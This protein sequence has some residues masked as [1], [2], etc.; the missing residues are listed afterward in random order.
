MIEQKQ[1]F[2]AIDWLRFPLAVMVVFIH[3]LPRTEMISA[4]GFPLTSSYGI[5][6]LVLITCSHVLPRLAVPTFFVI[7]SYLFYRGMSQWEWPRYVEKLKRRCWTLLIPYLIWN[8]VALLMRRE[9]FASV[10]INTF[11]VCENWQIVEN[12]LGWQ[13]PA[14][15]PVNGPLWFVRDLMVLV[16]LSPLLYA[17][18]RYGSHLFMAVMAVLFV[19]QTF[20]YIP[21]LCIDGLFFWTLGCYFALHQ[22]K[23]IKVISS[24][25]FLWLIATILMLC[26]CVYQDSHTTL[27][28]QMMFQLFLLVGVPT[29]LMGGF[30]CTQRLHLKSSKPLLQSCFLLYALHCFLLAPLYLWM[31]QHALAPGLIG[32]ILAY[33][34]SPILIIALLILVSVLMHRWLP[35]TTGI[36]VGNRK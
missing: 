30:F 6:N 28:N 24:S 36:L 4:P 29:L 7:S 18:V 10:G 31:Q 22:E 5:Y 15:Q 25:W 20:P 2:Q 11:W 17:C 19:S 14:T 26:Y 13:I 8:L 23:V 33:F 9:L 21:S 12:W 27:F 32:S 35:R 1:I 3:V 34:L 16:V